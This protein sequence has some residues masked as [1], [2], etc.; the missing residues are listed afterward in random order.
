MDVALSQPAKCAGPQLS[1]F[2]QE[3]TFA[4]ALFD[5]LINAKQQAISPGVTVNNVS[6]RVPPPGERAPMTI[7]RATAD[8]FRETLELNL[9]QF[10]AKAGVST[11]FERL[12]DAP[13]APIE[14][15]GPVRRA[16][17]KQ[18][19]VTQWHASSGQ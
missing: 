15:P 7:P 4:E 9:K 5:G 14:F 2:G 17:D 6:G 16:R 19:G 10:F 8:R 18:Q 3:P 13:P 11:R 1:A 12:E